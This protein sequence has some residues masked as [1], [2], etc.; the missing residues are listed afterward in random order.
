MASLTDERNGGEHREP[1]RGRWAEVPPDIPAPGWKDVALRLRERI[2]ADRVSLV[3]AGIAFYGLLALV[4]AL[5]AVMALSG[6]FV[7]PDEV[8]AQIDALSGVLPGEVVAIV[9]DQAIAVAGSAPQGLGLAAGA[10][11]LF[12]LYSASRGVAS[13]IQGLNIA[14]DEREERGFLRLAATT[15]ALTLVLILGLVIGLGVTVA[16]PTALGLLE[17]GGAGAT[18]ATVAV[19]AGLV[20]L[21]MLG[22]AVLY[23]FGPSRRSPEWAWVSPGAVAGCFGWILAS[24]GFA[25]YVANFGAYNESFG[26]LGGVIV[27]LLWFWISA[28]VVLMGAELNAELEAQTRKDTTVGPDAPMGRRGAT[29]ADRPGRAAGM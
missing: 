25:F 1:G 26:A 24:A 28:F 29:K 13:L 16:V 18:L 21:T 20:L 8:V 7:E 15:L 6:A 27:L 10:G 5:T 4:P 17:A 22:L 19:W 3:A 9:E 23:R 14:Y 11:L 2:G 12:A